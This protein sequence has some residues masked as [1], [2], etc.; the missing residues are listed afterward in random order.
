MEFNIITLDEVSST[1]DVAMNAIVQHTHGHGTIFTARSQSAG[2]GQRGNV[3]RSAPGRN[4][5]FSLIIEPCH[6]PVCEQFR[7]SEMAALAAI[8]AL[9]GFGISAR[10]KWPNDLYVGDCKIGGILIEHTLMGEY[11]SFSIIGIGI[12]VLETG[13]DPTLPNPTSVALL[14]ARSDG[15]ESDA[16]TPSR[17]LQAFCEAF[18][19]LYASS[20]RDDTKTLHRDYMSRLWRGTGSHPYRDSEGEFMASV[21]SID[22]TSGMLTL[23]RDG[24]SAPLSNYWFKEVE[25][26]IR[27]SEI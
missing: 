11:L 20:Q 18:D 3:W 8:R 14:L 19:D 22:P 23:R 17:L 6:I 4:L 13:F 1:N 5:T 27:K 2:R 12:N 10:I 7:I 25:S 24:E 26:V 16:A 21:E 9:G 15:R